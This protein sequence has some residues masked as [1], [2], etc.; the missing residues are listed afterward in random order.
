AAIY[1]VDGVGEWA[2]GTW[3]TA[4]QNA[5]TIEAETHFPN[6]LGLLYSAFTYYL[7]FEVNDGEYKVMGLAPYGKPTWLDKIAEVAIDHQDGSI[8]LDGRFF[9][10]TNPKRMVTE[11]FLDLFGGPPREPEARFTQRDFDIAMSIQR[12]TENVMLGAARYIHRQ[13]GLD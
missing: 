3:G 7:G 12:F 8:T 2:T 10:F 11:Q 4:R 6:S 5:I 13:T 9:D 1:T